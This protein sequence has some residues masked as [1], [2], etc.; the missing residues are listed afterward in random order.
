[1]YLEA[2]IEGQPTTLLCKRFIVIEIVT[3]ELHL[4]LYFTINTNEIISM[5]S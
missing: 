4:Q 5:D 2:Y 3:L 1:M